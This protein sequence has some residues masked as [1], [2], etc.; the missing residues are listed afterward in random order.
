MACRIVE[1]VA[2]R[3]VPSAVTGFGLA[4]L[5]GLVLVAGAPGAVKVAS[6]GG[7]SC[8]IKI[9]QTIVC[10]GSN[11]HGQATPPAGAFTAISAGTLHTCAIREGGTLA[12]WGKNDD[13]ESTP[14]AGTFTSVSAGGDHSCG[15]KSDQTLSCWGRNTQ[16][17][18]HNVAPAGTFTAVDAGNTAGTTWSCARAT[19]GT[20]ICW[21]YNAFGRGNYP[22]GSF[23]AVG[24]GGTHGCALTP[25][26]SI[27]CWGGQSSNGAPMPTPPAGIFGELSVGYD[28]TCA[29][30]NDQTLACLGAVNT[31]GRA[32]PPAG[33]FGALSVGDA[34]G[35]A[36]RT[37]GAVAC[38][39]SN[40]QGQVHP[41]P[42]VL[43]QAVG[44][45]SGGLDF[46]AQAEGTVSA[47]QE[48]T[49]TNAGSADL[50]IAGQSFRG[51]AEK[52]FFVGASTCL[53][54]VPGGGTCTLW[55][56]F[57]PQGE[58]DRER[59]AALIL[60]TNAAPAQYE[61]RL[62]GIATGLPQGPPGAQGPAGP[63]GPA[64]EQ[65]P[66]GPTGPQ[67]TPGATGAQGPARPS[68]PD[69]GTRP[70]GDYRL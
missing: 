41:V 48:V 15:V 60:D 21:G 37:N 68:G 39:G 18:P 53:E 42:A 61:V 67:G 56:R 24:A 51:A 10:W 31:D 43:T 2:L 52:D 32:T 63:A 23:A 47:P 65:G 26:A 30:R 38:W 7:H 44:Q 11:S 12:C 50:Q 62:L 58:K 8:S 49:V 35:C 28:H 14:P 4:I 13:G 3:T 57:S 66:A 45:V 22:P 20:I 16:F 55:V 64:G 36:V 9:D 25:A 34:H 19:A 54:P 46:A 6:G 70:G 33:T 59:E 5:A 1:R 69:R 27:T 40:A 17:P 29:I